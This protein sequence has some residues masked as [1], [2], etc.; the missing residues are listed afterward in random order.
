MRAGSFAA[1][2]IVRVSGLFAVLA[3]LAYVVT[4]TDF[5][6]VAVVA[7]A[8][9]LIQGWLVIRFVGR[10]NRE[11]ARFLDAIRYDDFLISF[12]ATKIGSGFDEMGRALEQ[13]M[14][15]FRAARLTDESRRRYLEALV[16]QVPVALLSVHDDGTVELLNSAARRLLNAPARSSIDAM[17]AYG[18]A[19]RRDIAQSRPGGRTLTRTEID[20]IERNLVLSTTQIVGGAGSQRVTSLQ[21]IQSE[22]D[23]NELGAWQDMV[24]VISHEI[25]NSLTPIAS[26]ARTADEIVAELAARSDDQELVDLR[27]AVQTLAR[28]STGLLRFV[29]SYRQLTQMPPPA[30]HPLALGDYLHRLDK[31]LESEWAGRGIVMHLRRPPEALELLADENLL[32]QAMINLLR[33]AADAAAAGDGEP[34]VWLSGGLSE[35]GRPIIEVADNGRGFADE[36][37]DKIFLPF[38]TTKPDGSGIGLA[39]ARQIM[40]VHKGAI[41]AAPRPGGGAVFRLTF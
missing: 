11:L 25:M 30:L 17:A 34:Q 40:L 4:S 19:F 36:I 12:S 7:G 5:H 28:R 9:A 16:E 23:T 21:D 38:F 10:T 13:A 31:L 20:G 33:N 24:R 3:A 35:R 2:L 37:R 8:V 41:T 6:A 27:D 29:R 18:E 14:H 32:D 15:R 39:L 1:Q 26:L 22:L